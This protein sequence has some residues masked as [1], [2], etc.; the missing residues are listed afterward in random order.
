MRKLISDMTPEE[1]SDELVFGL[2]EKLLK[3]A[4][5]KQA[6]ATEATALI[7][8]AL[9]DMCIDPDEIP[10]DAENA[11]TLKEA[12]CCYIDYGEYSIA[13][14]MKEV[15]GAYGKEDME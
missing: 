10:S 8:E 5:R 11:G 9:D 6:E 1:C 7:F 13:G 3:K 14:I 12:I 2:L 4:R 15:K